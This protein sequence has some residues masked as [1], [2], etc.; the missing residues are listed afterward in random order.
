LAKYRGLLEAFGP[1]RPSLEDRFQLL[2]ELGH[3]YLVR[4]ENLGSLLQEGMLGRMETKL[5]IP[6]LAQRTDYNSPATQQLIASIGG[7]SSSET[8]IFSKLF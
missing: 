5:L 7:P 4:P 6:F 3:L 1:A 8:R 2:W